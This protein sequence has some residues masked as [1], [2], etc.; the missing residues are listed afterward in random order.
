[1][2]EIFDIKKQ[3]GTMA[4]WIGAF[5]NTDDFFKYIQPWYCVFDDSYYNPE[6]N[7]KEADFDIERSK[8]FR[9]ENKNRTVEACFLDIFDEHFNRFKYDFGINFD[10]D[11]QLV[12]SCSALTIDT[13]ELFGEWGEL[14]SVLPSDKL[15]FPCN[16]FFA[17]PSSIYIGEVTEVKSDKMLMRF[18]GNFKENIFSTDIMANL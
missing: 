14:L 4:F 1:M 5:E 6:Y 16:C 13:K 2:A 3:A 7:F 17:Y 10:E 18:L 12:G 8:L 11:F 9:E 15:P